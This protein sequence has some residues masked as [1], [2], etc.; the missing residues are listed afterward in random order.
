[1]LASD[2]IQDKETLL[3]SQL[4]AP[5]KG[6]VEV[7]PPVMESRMGKGGGL[8]GLMGGWGGGGGG[9]K[10]GG[11]GS[12]KVIWSFSSFSWTSFGTRGDSFYT[13]NYV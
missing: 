11:K 2:V 9:G 7:P 8:E 1:M 13:N 3:T 5:V 6:D 10:K 12:K 4:P